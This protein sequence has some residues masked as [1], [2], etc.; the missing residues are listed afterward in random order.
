[1]LNDFLLTIREKLIEISL[2]NWMSC[3]LN[4]LN[5]GHKSIQCVKLGMMI[6]SLQQGQHVGQSSDTVLLFI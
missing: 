5:L 4:Y 1:M 2:T 6:F 3:C